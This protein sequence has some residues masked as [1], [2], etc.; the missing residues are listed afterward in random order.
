M[1]ERGRN[2]NCMLICVVEE[3]EEL[4]QLWLCLLLLKGCELVTSVEISH[5][6]TPSVILTQVCFP[7]K[8]CH[9]LG[10]DFSHKSFKVSK[11]LL[12]HLVT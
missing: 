1:A 9:G 8:K 2:G 5:G 3:E 10:M 7:Q 4:S 6:V 12:L 11:T